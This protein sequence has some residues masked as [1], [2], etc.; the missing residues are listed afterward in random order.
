MRADAKAEDVKRRLEITEAVNSIE[1]ERDDLAAKLR[2]QELLLCLGN[3]FRHCQ[4][5]LRLACRQLCC[6][7]LF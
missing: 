3:R 5:L 1:K 4:L 7:L 2:A 6:E